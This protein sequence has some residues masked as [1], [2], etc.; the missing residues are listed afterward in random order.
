MIFSVRQVPIG[1]EAVSRRAAAPTP[2]GV[3][4]WR[5]QAQACST[6]LARPM[7]SKA[8]SAPQPPVSLRTAQTRSSFSGLLGAV[9]IHVFDFEGGIN[10]V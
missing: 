10:F 4:A 1:M 3:P 8:Y 7:P 5:V 9:Q 6:G 2:I